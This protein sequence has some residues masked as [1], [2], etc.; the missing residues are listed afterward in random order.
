MICN[1]DC[2]NCPHPDCIRGQNKKSR[3][4]RSEAWKKYYYAN[5]DK[6]IEYG[7]KY[8]YAHQE[9]CQRKSREYYY[10]NRERIL[11]R[12]KAKREAAKL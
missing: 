5:R 10:K 6:F 4:S 1:E 3:T 11:A 9:E 2:F 8:Y 7:H 12:M